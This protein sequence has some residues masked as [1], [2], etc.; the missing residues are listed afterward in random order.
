VQAKPG[1]KNY[2]KGTKER[3]L[4]EC[5][6]IFKQYLFLEDEGPNEQSARGSAKGS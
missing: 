3:L 5:V 6:S 4:S 1:R 2:P